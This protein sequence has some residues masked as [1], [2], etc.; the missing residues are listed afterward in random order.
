MKNILV[1]NGQIKNIS[2]KN[3]MFTIVRIYYRNIVDL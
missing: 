2:A 1:S 3:K